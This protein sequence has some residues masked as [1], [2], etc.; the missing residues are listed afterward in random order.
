MVYNHYYFKDKF[1]YQPYA[2][3]DCH[4]FSMTV[5]NLSNFLLL[6]IKNFHHRLYISNIDKKRGCEYFK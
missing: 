1:D 2:C 3:N 5:I 6:T 4:E